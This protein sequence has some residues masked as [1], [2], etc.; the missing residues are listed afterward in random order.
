MSES[1][2][3]VPGDLPVVSA[4]VVSAPPAPVMHEGE[5]PFVDHRAGEPS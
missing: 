4:P 5:L 1:P 3:L 2:E